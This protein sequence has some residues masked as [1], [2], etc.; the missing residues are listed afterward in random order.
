ML[1]IVTNVCFY[2]LTYIASVCI[3]CLNLLVIA[4]QACPLS[5]VDLGSAAA[6][7]PKCTGGGGVRRRG[8][9][10]S[11]FPKKYGFGFLYIKLIICDMGH[12]YLLIF[13]VVTSAQDKRCYKLFKI[14]LNQ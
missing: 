10:E 13:V 14:Q 3:Y 4:S 11:K 2:L 5:T 1:I 9:A 6:Y 7:V 8:E 12:T